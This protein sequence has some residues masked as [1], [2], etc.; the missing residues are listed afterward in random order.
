[1]L[2]AG[3]DE[4][5]Y[6]PILGPLTVGCCMVRLPGEVDPVDLPCLWKMLRRSVSRRRDR[7]GRTLHINDSK[8]VYSP[9][10]GLRELER[11][12]LAWVSA[13]GGSTASL[14]GTLDSLLNDGD[15][16]LS[17]IPWY[18]PV[19]AEAHP[20][21]VDAS[22]A[23]IGANALRQEATRVGVEL[24]PPRVAIVPEPT[25]NR[26]CEATRN[27]SSV[28]FSTAMEKLQQVM[29]EARPGEPVAVICDRHGGRS[30]YGPLLRLMF[31]EWDL[32]VLEETERSA[33]YLMERNAQR[34][35][36]RF[37][38]KA[39]GACLPTA[40]ASMCAKYVRERLMG[41]LNHWWA[42]RVPDLRSTA[43]YWTDGQRFL[44]DIAQAQQE[45]GIAD[46]LLVR[47]R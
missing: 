15:D 39:D 42:Q 26:M 19:E 33:S 12:V 14:N 44:G 46:G 4:A 7:A 2:L 21:E 41:R 9:S 37:S 17:Q 28:L 35:Y 32:C 13:A 20:A 16:P 29:A 31:E 5:G 23:L 47:Q 1:M 38:E 8:L 43:G 22:A 3:I 34:V 18:R 10:T 25:F 11:S 45:A 30:H 6:G 24:L 27:K 36:L 40:M